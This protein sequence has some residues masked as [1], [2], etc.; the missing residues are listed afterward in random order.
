MLAGR[1]K[2]RRPIVVVFV[3]WPAR[4]VGARPSETC[5]LV[6]RDGRR[7]SIWG[8]AL[9]TAHSLIVAHLKADDRFTASAGATAA[10]VNSDGLSQAATRK[11]TLAGAQIK[12]LH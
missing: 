8:W 11:T 3:S 5:R 10:A 1:V 7:H 4:R 2:L 9:G 6:G 12:L